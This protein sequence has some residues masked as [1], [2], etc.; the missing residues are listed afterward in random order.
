MHVP[1][2]I[3]LSPSRGLTLHWQDGHVSHYAPQFL[4]D[5]CPCAACASR[6]ASPFPLF[7]PALKITAAEHVGAYALRLHFSDGHSSGLYTF[8]RLRTL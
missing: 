5:R 7:Q 1:T 2:R 6:S 8:D 3:A 4:R